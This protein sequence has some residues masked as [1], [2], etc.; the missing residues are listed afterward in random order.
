MGICTP[1]MYRSI[2]VTMRGLAQ[3]ESGAEA[4]ARIR[5]DIGEPADKRRMVSNP[6]DNQNYGLQDELRCSPHYHTG[7]YSVAT[8][9]AQEKSATKGKMDAALRCDLL[10]SVGNVNAWLVSPRVMKT[11]EAYQKLLT[12]WQGF[13]TKVRE[14]TRQRR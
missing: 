10:R 6:H 7:A 2:Y 14:L 8:P 3:Y 12:T 13:V 1:Y 11:T 4:R 5:L 9:N